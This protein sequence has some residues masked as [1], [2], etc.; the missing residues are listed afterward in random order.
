MNSDGV[1]RLS[2]IWILSV[3]SFFFRKKLIVTCVVSLFTIG[4]VWSG[5]HQRD[6]LIILDDISTSALI[7]SL[8]AIHSL[9][10]AYDADILNG[11]EKRNIAVPYLIS[12]QWLEE[13]FG[14]D[15]VEVRLINNQVII[16]RRRGRI[17]SSEAVRVSG[18]VEEALSGEPMPMVN[19]GLTGRP[20]GTITNDAGYFEFL[21]PEQFKGEQM[22]FSHLGYIGEKII[23]P[24]RDTMVVVSLASSSVNLPEVNILYQDADV[25]MRRASQRVVENYPVFPTFLTAFFRETIQQD[26]RFVDVSE[27]VVEILKPS[28]QNVFDQERVRFIRGRKGRE[29]VD[30]DLINFRLVGGPYHFSRLDVVRNGD[31]FYNEEGYSQYEYTFNGVDIVFDR[32]VYRVGFE[33]INDAESLFYKGEMRIDAESYALV[34][35]EFELTSASIRRS[36]SY[37]VQRDARRFRTTPLFARYLVEYRPW[38]DLW[39]LSRVKGEVNLR[40]VDRNRRQRTVFHTVSEMLV[41]DHTRAASQHRI[42]WAETFRPSYVLSEHLGDFDPEFWKEYNIIQPDETLEKVFR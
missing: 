8:T 37:L 24:S 41:S 35:I 31:F 10:F 36:R 14:R 2:I 9:D 29:T 22:V 40:V 1:T 39:V 15:G 18:R 34:S 16:G 23:V 5:D 13:V 4:T 12:E 6:S 20:M 11:S 3:I 30:M 21:V 26:D 17:L 19:I 38:G 27:A 42:R 7:D 25:I 33:P 28:Y 32:M